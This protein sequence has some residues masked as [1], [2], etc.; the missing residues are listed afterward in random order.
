METIHVSPLEADLKFNAIPVTA[1]EP[2]VD[3]IHVTS[4][5]PE[6]IPVTSS[7][8][9]ITRVTPPEP[10]LEVLPIAAHAPQLATPPEASLKTPD[11]DRP[12]LDAISVTP[13]EP[14]CKNDVNF[15]GPNIAQLE[16][17][18]SEPEPRTA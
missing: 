2:K 12:E 14:D 5:E 8:P 9:E 17:G 15:N 7:E 6:I 16:F 18:L 3:I 4:S 11:H 1:A 13:T 10:E